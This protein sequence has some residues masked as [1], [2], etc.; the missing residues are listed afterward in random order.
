MNKNKIVVRKEA[1]QELINSYP[2]ENQEK[3]VE[4]LKEEYGIATNQSIVSR[5]LRELNVTKRKLKDKMVYEL[6][7]LD[8]Q[9]E[10]LRLGITD[11]VH[12]DMLIV[13]K[14]LPGLAAFV[15]DYLDLQDDIGILAT[16]AGE[17]VV[18]VTPRS[19]KNINEVF[20]VLCQL[21]HFKSYSLED[22]EPN[23]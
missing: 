23:I 22:K 14:T 5:D 9:K 21:V 13:I 10:I 3:L 15:G 7:E 20:T 18:F 8:V 19:I 11:V 4:L 17:N 12:N 6:Q 16:L 2:V 1:I